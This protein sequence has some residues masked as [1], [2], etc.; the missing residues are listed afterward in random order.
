MI[1]EEDFEPKSS[2]LGIPGT[3]YRLLL[4]RMNARWIAKVIEQKEVIT[5]KKIYGS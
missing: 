3:S 1:F 2:M 5:E 4:G